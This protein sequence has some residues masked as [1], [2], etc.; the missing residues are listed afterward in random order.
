MTSN[1]TTYGLSLEER[2][3][4]FD[5]IRQKINDKYRVRPLNFETYNRKVRYH[6]IFPFKRL[7]NPPIDHSS[8]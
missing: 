1:E 7:G 2:I 3:S 5:D 6:L 4:K 8:H